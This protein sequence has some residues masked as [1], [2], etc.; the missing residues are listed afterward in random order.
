MNSADRSAEALRA[1]LKT[2]SGYTY[3]QHLADRL[4]RDSRNQGAFSIY[5]TRQFSCCQDDLRDEIAQEFFLFLLH[6]FLPQLI[7]RPEQVNELLTGQV[8]KV[9]NFS[10][11]QF[12]WRLQDAA[13]LKAINQRAY[14]HRRLRE[15][16]QLDNRFVVLKDGQKE[17]FYSLAPADQ[18][19]FRNSPNCTL[20]DYRSWTCP[21]NPAAR[22]DLFT[23]KYLSGVA[24]YLGGFCH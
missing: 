18:P 19:D 5:L 20:F 24:S 4:I 21:P 12:A 16:L 14:L 23:A 7:N 1:W 3:V 15:I 17:V 10:L 13:R 2:E 6:D 8:R 11:R 9:L 22:D